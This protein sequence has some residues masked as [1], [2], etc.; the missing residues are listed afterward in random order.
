MGPKTAEMLRVSL[1]F[2]GFGLVGCGGDQE[3]P[4]SLLVDAGDYFVLGGDILLDK[5]DENHQAIIERLQGG[6][7]EGSRTTQGLREAIAR[8]WPNGTVPY[9]FHTACQVSPGCECVDE[10][11]ECRPPDWNAERKNSVRQAMKAIEQVCGVRFVETPAGFTDRFVSFL[12]RIRVADDLQGAAGSSTMGRTLNPQVSLTPEILGRIGGIMHELLHGVGLSH[13]HQRFDRDQYI[14]VHWENVLPA[15]RSSLEKVPERKWFL[16]YS[17]TYGSYDYASIM[18]YHEY[19]FSGNREKT[20]DAHG[21]AVGQQDGLSESDIFT[22]Q[23][24][25]GRTPPDAP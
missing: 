10:R 22:L 5:Q 9:Y 6:A 7:P 14:T 1:L 21:N 17:E 16:P 4:S 25:Y 23:T 12:Y 15:H 2:A 8:L 20:I 13:E 18:H 19:A 11:G 3:S 24:L